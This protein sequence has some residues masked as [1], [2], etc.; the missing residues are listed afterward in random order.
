MLV[1]RLGIVVFLGVHS[2]T[3]FREMRTSLIGLYVAIKYHL[4]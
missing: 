2:L 4:P 3:P 1:L